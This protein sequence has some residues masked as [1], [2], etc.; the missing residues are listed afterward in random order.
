MQEHR[1]ENKY[2]TPL[3]KWVDALYVFDDDI[4]ECEKEDDALYL[5]K[6]Y[7]RLQLSSTKQLRADYKQILRRKCPEDLLRNEIIL[8]ILAKIQ[9]ELAGIVDPNLL[10][11]NI[12]PID[13]NTDAIAQASRGSITRL[14]ERTVL[15]RT[16]NGKIYII[17]CRKDFYEYKRK[18]YDSLTEIAR[19]ITGTLCSGPTFFSR[20]VKMYLL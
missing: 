1:Q 19:E 7:A 5:I 14:A 4:E 20:K 16:Y 18:H 13:F 10:P 2:R 12:N 8:S 11:A 9:N 6:Q 15:E 17:F 3:Q